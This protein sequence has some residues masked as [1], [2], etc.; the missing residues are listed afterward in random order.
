MSQ[1]ATFFT[2]SKIQIDALLVA[3]TPESKVIEKKGFLFKKKVEEQV[4][5]FWDFLK[6]HAKEQDEY[7]YSG[8]GFCDLE[9][10]LEENGCELSNFGCCDL[11][12]KLFKAR[13]TSIEVF[14]YEAARKALDSMS[15][16][17]L[18]E[19]KVRKYYQ[20]NN[21]PEDEGPGTEAVLAAFDIYKKWLASVADDEIGLLL[22]G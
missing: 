17:N 21:P 12:D 1:L 13:S 20:E 2:L 16:I 9:L 19:A 22:V 14:D 5:H 18:S 3:A 11:A 7:Q 8:T 15:N 6:E 10:V 4:D